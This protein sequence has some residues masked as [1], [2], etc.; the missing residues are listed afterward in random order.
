MLGLK[1]FVRVQTFWRRPFSP[2]RKFCHPA[3]ELGIN[4][5][6]VPKKNGMILKI[7]KKVWTNLRIALMTKHPYKSG[8]WGKCSPR[9]FYSVLSFKWRNVH[10]EINDNND[11][12]V[13]GKS[14][15]ERVQ[16]ASCMTAWSAAFTVAL[17]HCCT[18]A[19]LIDKVALSLHRPAMHGFV[20]VALMCSTDHLNTTLCLF[21]FLLPLDCTLEQH[22]VL[23]VIYSSQL[24]FLPRQRC[25]SQGFHCTESKA[26]LAGGRLLLNVHRRWAD[27]LLV[28]RD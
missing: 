2:W 16:C 17:L 5:R 24:H 6:N 3:L 27:Y 14:L 28:G 18:V 10:G 15:G 7:W 8:F 19:L 20:S 23:Q 12:G 9:W 4:V 13:V 25:A 11:K 26:R 21:S 22:I 1:I